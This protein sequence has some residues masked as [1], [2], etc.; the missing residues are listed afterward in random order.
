MIKKN[1][2]FK[3]KVRISGTI[4]FETAFHIGSG[5][6]G[7][8][9]T[10]MGVLL[11]PAGHPILPGS[12]LKGNFR[13]LAEGLAEHL[14]LKACMLDRSISNVDNCVNGDD[15]HRDKIYK[16]FKELDNESK[17]IELLNK[18]LC[19]VCQLFGSPLH[20]S[21]IFF[22]DGTL[23][24]YSG[25]LQVRDGVCID[26]D[27]ET[28]RDKAKYDYEVVPAGA[29]FDISIDIDNPS[30]NDLALVGAALA[31]W[32]NGFRLGGFTSRGLGKVH[33]TNF[34][35]EQVDYTVPDQLKDYLLERK[36]AS[37]DSLLDD[38][39]KK[40]LNGDCHA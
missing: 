10:N 9:A 16:D 26:R 30:D 24:E 34:T 6:E 36:M 15:K 4:I 32:K 23:K 25:N 7:E 2:S 3:K 22:S 28:A 33:F 12:T 38:A 40:C 35:I 20:A 14:G 37:A 19:N 1:P 27:T 31:E 5:N 8:L 29:L 17:K 39:L 13:S 11:D 18:N 21:R